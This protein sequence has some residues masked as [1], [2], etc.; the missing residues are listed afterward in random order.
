MSS[1]SFTLKGGGRVWP[2]RSVHGCSLCNLNLFTAPLN[3]ADEKT[4]LSFLLEWCSRFSLV[5]RTWAFPLASEIHWTGAKGPPYRAG[6]DVLQ[7]LP[8]AGRC[9]SLYHAINSQGSKSGPEVSIV[10]WVRTWGQARM[11]KDL[12]KRRKVKNYFKSY[13]S[14]SAG[15]LLESS[16]S[17]PKVLFGA[18]L[19]DTLI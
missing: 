14:K 15:A 9:L 7:Q 12:E 16:K 3:T 8:F 1:G 5:C 6:S 18:A 13:K 17:P 10:V 2:T 11:E 19:C 4:E